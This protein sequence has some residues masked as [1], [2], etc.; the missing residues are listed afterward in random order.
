MSRAFI[1]AIARMLALAA[2]AGGCGGLRFV[3]RGVVWRDPDDAPITRPRERPVDVDWSAARSVVLQP[4]DR[5]LSLDYGVEAVNVNALDEVPESSWFHDP[6]RAPDGGGA[7]RPRALATDEMAWGAATPDDVP[8]PPLTIVKGKTVGAMLGF[9]V[10][11]ARGVRYM[12]KLDP[13][14]RPGF[15]T[16]VE[17]VVSRLA[18]A[19]GWRVPKEL[20]IALAPAELRIAPSATAKDERDRAR[21]FLRDDL[22]RMLA[23]L[24]AAAGPDGRILVLASRW[25]AGDSLGPFRYQG[26]RSDDP[27][28]RWPHEDRRELRGFGVFSAWVNNVDTLENNTLDMYEGAPGR[29][30]VVHYQQDVGG[31]FGVWANQ[32]MRAW[33]GHE[34][35]FDVPHILGALVSLGLSSGFWVE[36]RF[37]DE[38]RARDAAEPALGAFAAERFDPRAWR[39]NLPNA[40]FSRQTARDRYWAAKRIALVD[41]RELRAAIAAGRYP[42]DVAGRLYEILWRRRAAVL[43]AYFGAVTA[44]DYF[45]VEGGRLCFDDL[46]AA[47]GLGAARITAS[48]GGRARAV[49][50]SVAGGACVEGVAGSGYHV[51]ALSASRPQARATP[52]V[53]VHVASG[54]VVGVER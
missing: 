30:H 24:A 27:N 17:V 9:V 4:I 16:S 47:A 50:S 53:R 26:R 52:P 28:D 14:G 5:F 51:V 22:A 29:G 23:P 1:G 48:D 31:A 39:P 7:A 11:D 3:E 8:V 19:C 25:L 42:A 20:M 13:P 45:R 32:P 6:R 43:R 37:L 38:L 15:A 36:Q 54:R 21:P 44:L 40:A 34:T 49:V 33:M 10:K 41:E 46:G 35:Y 2:V 12:V 18:W